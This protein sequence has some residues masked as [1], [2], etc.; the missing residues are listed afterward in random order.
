[1]AA[2]KPARGHDPG[3]HATQAHGVHVH[4]PVPDDDN[5]KA[6][7]GCLAAVIVLVG[8]GLAIALLADFSQTE[9]Q[10]SGQ[11]GAS[12]PI[13]KVEAMDKQAVADQ[14]AGRL[15]ARNLEPGEEVGKVAGRSG[16]IADLLAEFYEH[17][18]EPEVIEVEMKRRSVCYNGRPGRLVRPILASD[19]RGFALTFGADS[20]DQGDPLPRLEFFHGIAGDLDYIYYVSLTHEPVRGFEPAGVRIPNTRQAVGRV[21]LEWVAEVANST[22]PAN[23]S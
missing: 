15:L 17:G 6:A 8:A 4:V 23:R 12:L 1:M 16:V 2:K 10:V 20:H 19:S 13:T 5:T 22:C 14:P 7:I 21:M 9:P 11:T 3:A 18:A